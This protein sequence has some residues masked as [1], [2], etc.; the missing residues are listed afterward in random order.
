MGRPR[1]SS[2][3]GNEIAVYRFDNGLIAEVWFYVD[4]H[5]PEAFF[6]RVRIRLTTPSLRRC[7]SP[8]SL[9]LREE[10]QRKKGDLPPQSRRS[11]YRRL[12][13][14]GARLTKTWEDPHGD[15]FLGRRRNPLRSE[16][17]APVEIPQYTV[18][19]ILAVWAAA[20]LPMG[21]LA[22]LVAPAL[23]DQFGGEGDV[24]ILKALLICLTL[25]LI[26]QFVLVVVLM[27][28]EQ[29]A[30]LADRSGKRSGYVLRGVRAPAGSAASCG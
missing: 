4:G 23:E 14:P 13:S 8:Q 11:D 28:R 27:R 26:W 7:F 3:E 24:P 10:G 30:P 20:A 25:G 1:R 19:R 15:R 21:A 5:E 18:L 6:G 29:D 12:G 16:T 22:W 2:L 17:A 9:F